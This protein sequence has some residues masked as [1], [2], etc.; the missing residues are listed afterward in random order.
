MS[1]LCHRANWRQSMFLCRTPRRSFRN[2]RRRC[3]RSRRSGSRKRNPGTDHLAKG[4]S[5]RTPPG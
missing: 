2:F 4:E 5:D 1:V 3:P